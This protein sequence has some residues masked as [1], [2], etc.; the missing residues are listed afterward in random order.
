M[1]SLV[2]T[3]FLFISIADSGKSEKP[4]RM[5]KNYL[6]LILIENLFHLA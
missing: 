6:I 4:L 1:T 2:A 3:N 5:N